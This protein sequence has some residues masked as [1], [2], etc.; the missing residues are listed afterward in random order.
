[1]ME[2]RILERGAFDVLGVVSRV[3]RGTETPEMFRAIWERFESLRT[4]IEPRSSDRM[5]YGI[6]FPA[7]E[8]GFFHYL[9]GMAVDRSGATDGPGIPTAVSPRCDVL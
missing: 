1:M 8:E 7:A 2:P 5:Y 9:A 6:S 4:S 3:A